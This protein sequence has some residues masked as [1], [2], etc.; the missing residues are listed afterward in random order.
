MTNVNLKGAVVPSG[1][2][3]KFNVLGH[4]ITSPI[5]AQTTGGK[6]YVFEML[7][8]PGFGVPPH[9]HEREDELIYIVAGEFEIILEDEKFSAHTGD[10]VFFPRHVA[11]AFQN[12]G[13]KPGKAIFTISPGANFEEFFEEMCVLPAGEPDLQKVTEIFAKYGMEV[14][15]PSMA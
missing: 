9:V 13:S 1:E 10:H 14:L 8:P 12:V 3:K 5:T 11:H 2:G 6:Y 7:T 15:I 4:A